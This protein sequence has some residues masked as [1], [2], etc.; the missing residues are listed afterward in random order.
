MGQKPIK[1]FPLL[2]K[3]SRKCTFAFNVVKNPSRLILEILC[4]FV[5]V[6]IHCAWHVLVKHFPKHVVCCTK[7]C[8]KEVRSV[9]SATRCVLHSEFGP[10][11]NH[12]SAAACFVGGQKCVNRQSEGF[13]RSLPS[14]FR[15]GKR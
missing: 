3:I 11:F 4:L 14:P 5:L 9:L 2:C 6:M 15:S 13:P 8:G 7:F 12:L 1:L 10:S